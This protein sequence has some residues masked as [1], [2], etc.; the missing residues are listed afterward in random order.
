M[1]CCSLLLDIAQV[2]RDSNELEC[3][4]IERFCNSVEIAIVICLKFYCLT[5]L[6]TLHEMNEE[7]VLIAR[8][9]A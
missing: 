5:L 4:S 7:P 3:G 9:A 1:F 6:L 8:P 2:V